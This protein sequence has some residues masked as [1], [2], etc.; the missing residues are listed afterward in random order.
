MLQFCC[1]IRGFTT[2]LYI[3]GL[4]TYLFIYLL[5]VIAVVLQLSEHYFVIN[6]ILC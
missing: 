1:S 4:F 2:M 6:M 5:S 3:N